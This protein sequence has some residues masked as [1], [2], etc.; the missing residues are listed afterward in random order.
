MIDWLTQCKTI[1][2]NRTVFSAFKHAESEMVELSEELNN[3]NLGNDQGID[4]I[5]GEATDVILCMLDIISQ[6]NPDLT[7]KELEEKYFEQKFNKWKQNYH[8]K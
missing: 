1:K 5:V 2:N 4:G 3:Y 6:Y 8:V 7:M